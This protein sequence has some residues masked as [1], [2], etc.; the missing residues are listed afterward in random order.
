M[1]ADGGKT[2]HAATIKPAESPGRGSTGR[3]KTQV[4][5]GQQLLMSRA[6]DALGRTQPIDG[7]ALWNPRGYEW[8]GVERLDVTFG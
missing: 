1:S 7:L 8:N 4:G 2:W 5:T 3:L 6:T